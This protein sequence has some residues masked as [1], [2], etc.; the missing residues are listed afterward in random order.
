MNRSIFRDQLIDLRG[1]I[2]NPGQQVEVNENG[3]WR[4]AQIQN[5]ESYTVKNFY[6]EFLKYF[7]F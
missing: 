7:F 3:V 2:Y 1:A 6:T 4:P 5:L